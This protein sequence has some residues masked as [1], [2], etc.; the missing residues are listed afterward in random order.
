MENSCAFPFAPP[1]SV[2]RGE[3]WAKHMGLERGAIGNTPWGIHW[4]HVENKRKMKNIL[5]SP[6]PPSKTQ[7]LK[8][9]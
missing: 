5:P 4:E 8:E 2:R 3:L 7:N 1:I 6:H 9:K